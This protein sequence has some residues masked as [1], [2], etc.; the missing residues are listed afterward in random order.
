MQSIIITGGMTDNEYW[1]TDTEILDL[2]EQGWIKGPNLPLGI[3]DAS[4]VALPPTLDFASLLIGGRAHKYEFG[5]HLFCIKSSVYGLKKSL[6]EWIL[7]GDFTRSRR[8]RYHHI[9]LP[10]S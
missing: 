4:C 10:C 5:E 6:D 7:L 3:H 8:G 2:K 1:S 9:A